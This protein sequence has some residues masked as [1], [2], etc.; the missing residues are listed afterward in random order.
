MTASMLTGRRLCLPAALAFALPLEHEVGLC[1][2]HITALSVWSNAEQCV[3]TSGVSMGRGRRGY[4]WAKQDQRNREMLAQREA[5]VTL[6]AIGAAHGVSAE[7]VRQIVRSLGVAGRC[8]SVVAGQHCDLAKAMA[9]RA[10]CL[11]NR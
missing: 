9:Q 4:P 2:V 6:A 5:G 11:I 7:R 8:R 1:S 3:L 10:L